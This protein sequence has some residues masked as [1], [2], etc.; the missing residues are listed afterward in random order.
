MSRASQAAKVGLFVALTGAAAYGV[1]RFVTPELGSGGGYT[2]HA[3]IRDATGLAARSRVTIAGIP[4]GTLDSIK[5]ERGEARLNVKVRDDGALFDNATLGKKS[6]S[7][8]GESVIVL[9]PGTPD[10]RKLHD[11]DEIHV[12]VEEATPSQLMDEVKE[13]ADSVKQ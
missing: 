10:H 12:I 2:V 13:I 7:L 3:F 9:T 4:V 6:T 1:Y 5:L 11:G 8:L